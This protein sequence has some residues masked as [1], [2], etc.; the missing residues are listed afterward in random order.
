MIHLLNETCRTFVNINLSDYIMVFSAP[1]PGVGSSK[2]P[3]SCMQDDV[4]GWD[5]VP[6]SDTGIGRYIWS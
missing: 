4:N 5:N 2:R 6:V 1:A 3:A